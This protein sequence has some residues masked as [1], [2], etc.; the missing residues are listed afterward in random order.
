MKPVEVKDNTYSVVQKKAVFY[1]FFRIFQVVQTA[2]LGDFLIPIWIKLD[3]I[4]SRN[5]QNHQE[6]L[7]C[8]I[9]ASDTATMQEIFWQEQ[10]T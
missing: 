4:L 2:G 5:G 1:N 10:C 6:I 8:K 9:S 7:C 3:A